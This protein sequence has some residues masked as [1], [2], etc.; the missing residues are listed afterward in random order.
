V[1]MTALNGNL[2]D[3][4]KYAVQI[5]LKNGKFALFFDCGLGKTLMQL[6]W[7]EMVLEY[8]AS[9]V[10]ILAPL[11]V[12]EQTINE[13]TK[14]GI[15][16]HKYKD[17]IRKGIFISNYEQLSNIDTSKFSGI[18]LDESSILKNSNGKTSKLLIDKFKITPYKL[19]CTATPSPNDHMELGQ[20]C[21]FL[22]GMSYLEMLSMFFVH[23]AG[24][25]QKWR[26]R[27]HAETPF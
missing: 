17:T 9:S 12:V 7:A 2:F 6:S 5:A 14:F 8:S 3:F 24:E 16:I 10:L 22:G 4:Q 13:G 15:C 11:C 1:D 23:D 20:H 26:L 18:I 21:E 27:K 19:A 25:T